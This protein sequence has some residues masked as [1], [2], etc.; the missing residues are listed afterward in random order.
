M[1]DVL[2]NLDFGYVSNSGPH[3]FI[4]RGMLHSGEGFRKS[5]LLASMEDIIWMG[6]VRRQGDPARK[7][8]PSRRG[9]MMKQGVIREIETERQGSETDGWRG[10]GQSRISPGF[11]ACGASFPSQDT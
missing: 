10:C 9:G 11:L 6:P 2:S 5:P 1:N 8:A 3:F 7:L 4:S